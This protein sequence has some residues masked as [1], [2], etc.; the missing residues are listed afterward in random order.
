MQ[1]FKNY[2]QRAKNYLLPD[3]QRKV[4]KVL[5]KRYKDDVVAEKIMEVWVSKR[6]IEGQKGRRE[7]LV[8][9]QQKISEEEKLIE[10]LEN[11]L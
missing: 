8:T 1:F 11:L 10:Y 7:E 2:I 6:I 4:V 9:M 5:L 3:R